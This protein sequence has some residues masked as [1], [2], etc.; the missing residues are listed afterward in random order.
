M[1]PEY[2]GGLAVSGQEAKLY[3][4]VG[5]SLKWQTV[6]VPGAAYAKDSWERLATHGLMSKLETP[7]T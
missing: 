5:G 6:P 7:G 3:A 2:P 4:V 1:V